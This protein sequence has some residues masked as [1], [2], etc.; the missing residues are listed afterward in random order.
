[1]CALRLV[2]GLRLQCRI[3]EALG[4]TNRDSTRCNQASLGVKVKSR[5]GGLTLLILFVAL[6]ALGSL[7][8]STPSEAPSAAPA[9]P[10]V[11]FQVLRKTFQ[12]PGEPARY[13]THMTDLRVSLATDTPSQIEDFV[14]VQ[15]V[16]GC[17]F[18][19]D[20][21]NGRV[22]K[23]LTIDRIHQ[24][25]RVPFRHSDWAI[26]TETRDPALSS[27][28]N[29]GRF[30]RLRW[31]RDPRSSNPDTA[32]WYAHAK[33]PHGT[34]FLAELISHAALN[35][36]SP[37]G[38]S[39]AQNATLEFRACVFRA[40]DVP[41]TV[42]STIDVTQAIVCKEWDHK[43]VWDFARGRMSRPQRI[44]PVCGVRP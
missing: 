39:S 30:G 2:G 12:F 26:D 43:Y 37:S 9:A 36:E 6:E 24:G 16:R 22:T 44:D 42:A 13:A 27:D 41:S 35:P 32:T 8:A 40:M 17:A 7:P 31:N 10:E 3:L 20:F 25:E 14:V 21:K 29:F 11:R 23:L 5:F 18:H 4:F 1:M 28:A 34:V 15:L 38:E 19:S 33:P